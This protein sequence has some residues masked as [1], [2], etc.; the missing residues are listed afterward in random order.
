MCTPR[1]ANHVRHLDSRLRPTPRFVRPSA[2][3]SGL[4]FREDWAWRKRT[5]FDVGSVQGPKRGELWAEAGKF[6]AGLGSKRVVAG[7]GNWGGKREVV[8]V[9]L[10]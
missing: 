4:P 2:M 10:L 7:F 5:N 1:L 6:G 9:L 8:C 3:R